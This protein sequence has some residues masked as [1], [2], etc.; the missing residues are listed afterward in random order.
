[1]A[2]PMEVTL[3]PASDP[4]PVN[5]I[6]N[7]IAAIKAGD[8]EKFEQ[9]LNDVTPEQINTPDES[10]LSPLD[11][12]ARSGSAHFIRLLIEK[13]ADPHKYD[14]EGWRPLHWA[15]HEMNVE[16]I[17]AL[18][19][20]GVKVNHPD[21][22]NITPLRDAIDQEYCGNYEIGG[23]YCGN[24]DLKNTEVIRILLGAGADIIDYSTNKPMLDTLIPLLLGQILQIHHKEQL[25]QFDKEQL[26]QFDEEQ[27]QA[28]QSMAHVE[29]PQLQED[30]QRDKHFLE[31]LD[32]IEQMPQPQAQEILQKHKLKDIPRIRKTYLDFIYAREQ[33]QQPLVHESIQKRTLLLTEQEDQMRE[34][35]EQIQEGQYQQDVI[36]KVSIN[37]FDE[38]LKCGIGS[39]IVA[40][41]EWGAGLFSSS[42]SILFSTPGLLPALNRF[43]NL[44][45][46]E[47]SMAQVQ[48]LHLIPQSNQQYSAITSTQQL[49]EL[50][51]CQREFLVRLNPD[52]EYANKLVPGVKEIISTTAAE[53]ALMR[54]AV[55]YAVLLYS[56]PPAILPSLKETKKIFMQSEVRPELTATE[57][58]QRRAQMAVVAKAEAAAF[59]ACFVLLC[60]SLRSR[61]LV[62]HVVSMAASLNFAFCALKEHHQLEL[63]DL[64]LEQKPLP[65]NRYLPPAKPVIFT[66]SVWNVERKLKNKDDDSPPLHLPP[67]KTL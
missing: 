30:I 1:M 45:L 5:V 15:V 44:G 19:A 36:K 57:A 28:L 52:P 2:V 46:N 29:K 39:H 32:I 21:F 62:Q 67:V 25:E 61:D 12:A 50:P 54:R 22:S 64:T 33:M 9:C 40:L 17:Q 58:K 43:L 63:L 14:Q 7:L 16:A 65:L 10:G 13:G 48:I 3:P 42:T 27:I 24:L 26:Q 34:L 23:E 60:H 66:P 37:V 38:C 59:H 4:V 18:L 51:F 47:N 6:K 20:V 31:K 35:N 8:L 41:L 11:W 53:R 49:E 56:C 55:Q